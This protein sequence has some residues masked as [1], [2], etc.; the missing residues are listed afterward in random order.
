MNVLNVAVKIFNFKFQNM[1]WVSTFMDIFV[2]TATG[3]MILTYMIMMIYDAL[4]RHSIIQKINQM[5]SNELLSELEKDS[6]ISKLN[7]IAKED[8]TMSTNE[9]ILSI[10]NLF[11]DLNGKDKNLL[12]SVLQNSVNKNRIEAEEELLRQQ[13]AMQ[14]AEL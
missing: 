13:H 2:R 3:I 10:I 1:M 4:M 12:I 14:Q 11:R 5:I 6:L 8:I 7:L 9:K